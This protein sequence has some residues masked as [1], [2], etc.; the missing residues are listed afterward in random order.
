MW[1]T[2]AYTIQAG[3]CYQTVMVVS[4]SQDI[5]FRFLVS[6]AGLTLLDHIATLDLSVS[7]CFCIIFNEL[8]RSHEATVAIG[9]PW[10]AALKQSNLSDRD[11]ADGLREQELLEVR[12]IFYGW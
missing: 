5:S 6:A 10:Q 11:L 7:I 4:N 8:I 12:P 1:E 9:G 2:V 3:I